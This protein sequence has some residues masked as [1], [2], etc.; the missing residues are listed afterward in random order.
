MNRKVGILLTNLGTPDAPTPAA[1]RRYLQQ[2]LT[3]NR[4]IEIPRAIWCP[5]LYFFTY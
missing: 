3:D 5:I 1:L 2:F 4:V